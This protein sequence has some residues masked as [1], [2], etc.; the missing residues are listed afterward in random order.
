MWDRSIKR[1]CLIHIGAIGSL[2]RVWSGGG[3]GTV[4][5]YKL[6]DRSDASMFLSNFTLSFRFLVINENLSSNLNCKMDKILNWEYEMYYSS[7]F[8]NNQWK[9]L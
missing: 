8:P 7:R 2:L 5:V 4:C 9:F 3:R 6:Y 1:L